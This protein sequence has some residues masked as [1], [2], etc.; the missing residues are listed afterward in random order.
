MVQLDVHESGFSFV[1]TASFGITST[2]ESGYGLLRL[3]SPADLMLYLAKKE[4]RNRV[5][6]MWF[7]SMP[8]D[9]VDQR[10][11]RPPQSLTVVGG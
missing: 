11:K 2:A 7:I 10:N 4:G 1:V 9:A 3:L 5:R 8:V 6:M